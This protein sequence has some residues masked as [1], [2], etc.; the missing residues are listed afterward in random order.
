MQKLLIKIILV[1]GCSSWL[2]S[3]FAA[4]NLPMVKPED[5][6]FSSEQLDKIETHFQG[7]VDRGEIA[8]I[9]TLVARKGK[10][11]H[12]SAVGY[13]N[14]SQNIPMETDTLFRIFSMTKPIASTALMMI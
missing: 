4:D 8:G 6:G 11:A 2:C 12:L 13:Q 5:V 1:A 10:I 3:A 9:V 7:R 14:V